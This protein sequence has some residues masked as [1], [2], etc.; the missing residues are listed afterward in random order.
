MNTK[1][2]PIII[3]LIAA[4]VSCVA[5]IFQQA[6]FAV[7]TKRLVLSVLIFGT[8]GI[9]VRVILDR[10]V[11]VMD[12]EDEEENDD[13]NENDLEDIISEVDGEEGN[14]TEE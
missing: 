3:T 14:I 4:L 2:I 10:S 13:E 6:D 7:F 11:R 1:P 8:I 12:E 9:I 5:S